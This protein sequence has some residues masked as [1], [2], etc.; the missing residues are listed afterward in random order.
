MTTA[1]LSPTSRVLTVNGLQLH[2][3]DWGNPDAP[4][5]VCVHGLRSNAHAFDGFARRFADRYHVISLDVRGRGDSAWSP[6]GKYQMSDYA[7]DLLGI[8]DQLGLATFS[9]IGTSMGGR[10]GMTFAIDNGHRLSRLILNDIGPDGE[11]GSDR[12]TQEAGKAPD[13]FDSYESAVDYLRQTAGVA[14]RM[15]EE[16][17]Q[18]R[19][20]YTYK[21]RQDGRWIAKNDPEFLRQRA[22]AGT[23]HDPA[24]MWRAL[25]ALACPGLVLWGTVSDVL[26]EG[27]AR[28]IVQTL[29]NGT[30][31]PV[32]DV[33]HT[34]TLEEPAA[35]EALEKFLG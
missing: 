14:S 8:V 3:L 2:H 16:A 19:A 35:V 20:R 21:Q 33:G 29:R 24:P 9:Y 31:A 11:S 6:D 30:L 7:S 26:S 4:A 22:A 28:K 27:Q 1:T 10:I 32:P 18:E 17:L 23:A 12:I 25:E 13:S 34:P 15:S 5:L